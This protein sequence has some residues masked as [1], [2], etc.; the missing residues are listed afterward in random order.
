MHWLKKYVRPLDYVIVFILF[1]A[2]FIPLGI[3]SMT[4]AHVNT[5]QKVAVISINGHV[6]RRI[7]LDAHAGHQQFTL[8]P[9]K[10]E[11]NV[12]EV[13]GARIRDKEDN[14]PDQIAVHTGWIS[15]IGQQSI[16]LPHKLLIEIKPAQGNKGTSGDDG[17]L[18][19]P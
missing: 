14:S 2:C 10:G 16:C 1:I 13:D 15:Q 7:K 4:E 5:D 18:V 17:G 19:H 6:K 11:Y 3:F 8:Y 12:I 9:A